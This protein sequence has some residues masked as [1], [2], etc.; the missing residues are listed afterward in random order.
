L[1]IHIEPMSNTSPTETP[2]LKSFRAIKWDGRRYHDAT[3]SPFRVAAENP[4]PELFSE[5]ATRDLR[6]AYKL[7]SETKSGATTEVWGWL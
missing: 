6:G 3:T 4:N 5:C 1:R 2:A 7:W